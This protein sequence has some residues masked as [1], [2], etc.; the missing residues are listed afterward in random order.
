MKGQ[1]GG[2][3]ISMDVGDD[4]ATVEFDCARG[5]IT[6]QIVLDANGKFVAKGFYLREHPGPTRQDEDVKGKPATYSGSVHDQTMALEI[7]LEGN[8]RAGAYSLTR[9]KSG[10]IRKCA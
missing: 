6:D 7:V 3:G 9:G 2:Q 4:G 1:W 8:E 5:T 10:R